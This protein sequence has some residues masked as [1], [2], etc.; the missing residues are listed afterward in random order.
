MA[1]AKKLFRRMLLSNWGGIEH[2]ILEFHEY[3]NLFSGKS[4][5]GKSTVMDAMQV[6]LYGSV[7]NDF[8]NRAA[9]DTKNKRSVL[10]YLR[11]E[12]K[13]GT[14]NRGNVDFCSQIVMEIEDTGAQEHVST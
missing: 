10:S 7:R 3:V 8:L 1:Q 2:K 13:D 9:D 4:G 12:Q 6:I 14:A 11:G 5:S